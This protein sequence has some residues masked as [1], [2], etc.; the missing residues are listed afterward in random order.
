M[1]RLDQIRALMAGR[2]R[3]ALA[4][5]LLLAAMLPIA[6]LIAAVMP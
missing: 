5:I 4:E 6:V 2:E 3:D 1:N